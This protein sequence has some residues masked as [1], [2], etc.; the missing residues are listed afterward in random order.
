[1]WS[2][3]RVHDVFEAVTELEGGKVKPGS[4]A[5]PDGE[6]ATGTPIPGLVPIPSL[7][8]APMPARV[9]IV[10]EQDPAGSGHIVGY[11]AEVDPADLAA[12]KNPGYPFFVPGVAGHRAPAP[13]MDFA[14]NAEYHAGDPL[15]RRYL[16][17]GLSR[18]LILDGSLAN[19][20]H[21][22]WDFSKDT[23]VI[24]ARELPEDGTPVE[25]VAMAFH[26]TP[27]PWIPSFTQLGKSSYF[28][29]NGLPAEAGAPY[30]NPGRDLDGN[31][32]GT[33]RIYKAADLQTDVVFSKKGWHYPQER[34]IALW[35]DIAPT[36]SGARAPEPLFFRANSQTDVIEYW[37]TN[38]VPGYYE[39]DDFQLRTPTDVLGQH[40]HLVKFDV[41]ASDGAANG[42]NYEDG[43]LSPDEVRERIH[44]IRK[45]NDCKPTDPRD[46]TFAC[47][48]V[49]AAPSVFGTPPPGQDWNGAQTTI[50]RWYADPIFAHACKGAEDCDDRTLRTVF[51]HD[52]FSPSTHQ[53][54]GLYGGLLVEPKGSTW[55]IPAVVTYGADGRTRVAAEDVTMGTRDD[56]G[57]TSWQ[58]DILTRDQ[59][60]SYR[61]FGL[62]FQDTALAYNAKSPVR[63]VPYPAGGAYPT[64]ADGMIPPNTAPW[65]WADC[66]DAVNPINNNAGG[67]PACTTPNN[68][69]AAWPAIITGGPGSGSAVTNYRTE[70]VPLRVATPPPS[71]ISVGQAG[72][73]VPA[74]ESGDLSHVYRSICRKDQQ[75]NRQPRGPF[76][77]PQSAACSSAAPCFPGGFLGADDVDPYTPL[78]R[79]YEGDRVQVRLLAGAHVATHSFTTEG[80]RWLFEPSYRDSGFVATQ[81]MG[82]S[83]HFEAE[84]GLP[85]T[86][87]GENGFADY[88]Y[89]TGAGQDDL[90]Q[91]LWG[92]LRAYDGRQPV[93]GLPLLPNNPRPG[94]GEPLPDCPAGAP[95]QRVA[96]TAVTAAKALATTTA[97]VQY[98]ARGGFGGA[99]VIEQPDALLYVRSGDL[100]AAGHLRTGVPIE[101]LVVHTNA[102]DCVEVTLTNGLVPTQKDKNNQGI[103]TTS[104]AQDMGDQGD[105][106]FMQPSSEVGLRPQ[107]VQFDVTR[108]AA[109]NVGHNP[110][111]TVKPGTSRTFRWYAGID[112]TPAELGTSNLLPSD[113]LMQDPLGLLGAMVVEPAGST[114][115]EDANSRA[116]ARVSAPGG[117]SFRDFVL[118][119]QSDLQTI[120]AANGSTPAEYGAGLPWSSTSSTINAMSYRTEPLAYR[121]GSGS[122]TDVDNVLSSS[123]VSADPQT[124]IFVSALGQETRLRL[125]Q[126]SGTGDAENVT[127][128]GHV[129]QEEPFLDGS[130]RLG[131]NPLSEHFGTAPHGPEV[132]VNLLLGVAGGPAGVAGDYLYR[133][134]LAQGNF[135]GGEW[136]LFRVVPAGRDS[137]SV[138]T[139]GPC[140]GGGGGG[141]TCISGTNTVNPLTGKFAARPNVVYSGA[142]TQR[143]RLGDAAVDPSTGKWSY[144][145]AGA[146]PAAVTVVSEF[147][148]SSVSPPPTGGAGGGAHALVLGAAPGT[149]AAREPRKPTPVEQ[150]N[151]RRALQ[152]IRKPLGERNAPGAPAVEPV[153]RGNSPVPQAPPTPP[154]K[155]EGGSTGSSG[156]TDS[157]GAAGTAASAG[158]AGAPVDPGAAKAPE[159]AGEGG[160]GAEAP[161][162]K[163]AASD[164]TPAPLG[165]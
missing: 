57:P 95:A 2:L 77:N 67:Q 21:N 89:V 160:A 94:S 105:T 48:R 5:L 149:A 40:I 44:G 131:D 78:L 140:A 104:L 13:P 97:S 41:L 23:D 93:V 117:A 159:A 136:G 35:D 119:T 122:T 37:M 63:A 126:V 155:P 163:P 6:I 66:K 4:R 34:H 39:L 69:Y 18:H 88:L 127:V 25:K 42:F 80:L 56:G 75:L 108:N 165:S 20:H 9:T 22:Q 128:H 24:E 120:Q 113:P 145:F 135:S 28:E 151:L 68:N 109:F 46:G 38:L 17:G 129:W 132:N 118:F 29:V 16:D 10:P 26:A 134:F 130:R 55:K 100:D 36:V 47:P 124:P 90:V 157:T 115:V 59:A 31:A 150:A 43:S 152:F 153:G 98:N 103:F 19:E 101:P 12:H 139:I 91:G 114:V 125:A 73:C 3:W 142:G 32:V 27:K 141:G 148:A 112:G 111:Q 52:H 74:T 138:G 61:E 76:T 110:V 162:G 7:A 51:T 82:L 133:S 137:V 161:A 144:R 65:G 11:R 146:A 33:K 8:M 121:I 106:V 123:A 87:R 92:M 147:G 58:A 45:G 53:Q 64:T 96:I 14:P 54:A 71:N 83:E 50:Q 84:V 156:S 49:Q 30:A 81:S 60:R 70:P 158:S 116:S 154:T 79:A 143:T 62:E 102:G 1:M 107:L 99:P 85:H 164:A 15:S 86:A 72:D